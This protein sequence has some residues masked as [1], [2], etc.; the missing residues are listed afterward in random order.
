MH[1]DHL[2]RKMFQTGGT[3]NAK[4]RR[5]N[6]APEAGNGRK[7]EKSSERQPKAR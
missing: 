5:I 1:G 7:R 4:A 6:R 3:Q 2:R